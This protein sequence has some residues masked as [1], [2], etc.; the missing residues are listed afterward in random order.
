M[1]PADCGRRV[2]HKAKEL[3]TKARRHEGQLVVESFVGMARGFGIEMKRGEDCAVRGARMD[4]WFE[5]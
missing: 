3:N 2:E 4:G 1:I 5:S